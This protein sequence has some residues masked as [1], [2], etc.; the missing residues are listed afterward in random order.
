MKQGHPPSPSFQKDQFV[1]A[2]WYDSGT[3]NAG[4]IVVQVHHTQHGEQWMEHMELMLFPPLCH[5]TF[6]NLVGEHGRWHGP[7]NTDYEVREPILAERHSIEWMIQKEERDFGKRGNMKVESETFPGAGLTRHVCDNEACRKTIV[8]AFKGRDG[9]YCSNTCLVKKENQMSDEG[10]AVVMEEE[11]K[12]AKKAVKKGK[13]KVE[14]AVKVEAAKP[15]PVKKGKAKVE[16]KKG[17]AKPEAKKGKAEAVKPEPKKAK[18][19]KAKV[20]AKEINPAKGSLTAKL[21]G[22]MKREG[23]TTMKQM[24]KVAP[25]SAGSIL[26]AFENRGL[27]VTRTPDEEGVIHYSA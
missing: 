17:K 2:S 4:G 12:P 10:T 22:M 14:K 23:G 19:G 27:K 24:R 3:R 15:K 13:A 7:R 16:A 8:V 18:K 11:G 26:N 21:L 1:V 5:R 20:A 25:N 9:E 6:V